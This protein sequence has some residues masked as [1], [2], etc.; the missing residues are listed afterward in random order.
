MSG[1]EQAERVVGFLKTH[2]GEWWC[3]E[4]IKKALKTLYATKPYNAQT[5]TKV[6]PYCCS[7]YHQKDAACPQ[8][9]EEKK[10]T[11]YN[12]VTRP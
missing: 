8:C 5:T 11:I 4:C 9:G 3:D 10:L 7:D 6:L 1:S 2:K 12:P